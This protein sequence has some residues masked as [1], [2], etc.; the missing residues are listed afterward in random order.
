MVVLQRTR[1]MHV[2]PANWLQDDSTSFWGSWGK[3]Q[4]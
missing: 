1:N 3:T 4:T 2:G